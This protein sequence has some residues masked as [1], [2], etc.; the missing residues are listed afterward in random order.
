MF[1]WLFGPNNAT[2][3][4]GVQASEVRNNNGSYVSSL[5]FFPLQESH[6]GNYTCR[7]GNNTLLSASV[8]VSTCMSISFNSIIDL[9]YIASTIIN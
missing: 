7:V 8:Q 4:M 5:E 3:P 6:Q 9:A 2:P 1:E